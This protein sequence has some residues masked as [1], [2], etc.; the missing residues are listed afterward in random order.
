VRAL[1]LALILATPAAAAEFAIDY[2]R[3]FATHSDAVQRPAPG[4]ERLELPGPV[5]VE[6]RGRRIRAE[7]QSGWGPAGCA[8]RRLVVAAA[9]VQSCPDL[10]TVPQRDR[11]AGQLL[12]GVDFF[13]ENTVPP[14]SP[15]TR[16]AAMLAALERA[17]GRMALDCRDR[18]S[19]PLAFAAHIAEDASLRRFAKVFATP[20]LPVTEPCR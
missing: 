3:L 9:A 1:V 14:M 18:D 5:I 11:A 15:E 19:A 6:R 8:L 12:R 20:R 16:R 17:R 13:A 2:D 10:F 4:V 7:D